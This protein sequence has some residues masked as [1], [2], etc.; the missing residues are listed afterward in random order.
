MPGLTSAE[1][2]DGAETP[3][4]PRIAAVGAVA[5]GL[6][7]APVVVV[8]AAAA[9]MIWDLRRTAVP[10][11]DES[12]IA[13]YA[14]NL[15]AALRRGDYASAFEQFLRPHNYPPLGWSGL[16]L[17]FWV[18]GDSWIV[19]RA[20][21]ILAWA[22]TVL[23]ATRLAR[24]LAP[25]GREDATALTT[26]VLSLGSWL[27]VDLA[28]TAMLE[29]WTALALSGTTLLVV[30]AYERGTIAS[31]LSAG[32][33]L[34]SL[35]LVKYNYGV[36]A[37]TATVTAAASDV[38]LLAPG[39]FPGHRA[40]A[41]RTLAWIL[42]GAL[43]APAWWFVWPLPAGLAAGA[44]HREEAAT[45]LRFS[46]GIPG[47]TAR[48]FLYAYPIL[49]AGSLLT[50]AL[51]A[52]GAVRALFHLD[53]MAHRLCALMAGGGLLAVLTY[54]HREPRFLVP[55]LFAAW[56]LAGG[57]AVAA[58]GRWTRPGWVQGASLAG[59]V[60]LALGTA[61]IG[62]SA[63]VRVAKP[64]L[65]K[66]E[67]IAF[68]NRI[69]ALARAPWN[70]HKLPPGAVDT[71][72]VVLEEAAKNL[73]LRQPF[74]WITGAATEFARSSVV[75]YI[76]VKSGIRALLGTASQDTEELMS[77]KGWPRDQFEAWVA[78]YPQVVVVD[79]PS[80]DRHGAY[81]FEWDYHAWMAASDRYRVRARVPLAPD[82]PNRTL[83]V[84]ERIP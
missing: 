30:R 31:A 41:A 75:W 15:A 6:A 76:S 13:G 62:A 65:A 57:F 25:P 54:E 39:R 42:A 63:L 27:A 24:R 12:S 46:W 84:Y 71:K 19:G 14:L 48:E 40:R 59:L 29:S 51:Q 9:F 50:C 7:W 28:S 1:P 56:A 34:G 74:T 10:G 17:A 52:G 35:V 3:P 67:A 26:A 8:A 37:A 83:I 44:R 33:M 38:R 2:S 58:V 21:T 49:A 20:A 55:T 77:P 45:W 22:G 61:G 79:P 64:E 53:S 78:R 60:F 23:L 4:L 81:G 43:V 69:G 72:A 82:I 47:L 5:R 68:G 73:D 16:T 11:W 66:P 32:A 80:H 70:A 18:A 36:L